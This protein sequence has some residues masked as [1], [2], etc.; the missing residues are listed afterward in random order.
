M[1]ACRKRS[2]HGPERIRP[3]YICAAGPPLS[4]SRD[5]GM[6]KLV[7]KK[8][9]RRGKNLIGDE[10]DWTEGKSKSGPIQDLGKQDRDLSCNNAEKLRV[11]GP[12]GRFG[13]RFW[14]GWGLFESRS[15]DIGQADNRE[16]QKEP[17]APGIHTKHTCL[18]F[19]T[20]YTHN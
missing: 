7:K 9:K 8:K 14:D 20:L 1:R 15:L 13:F 17:L 6:Y 19:D 12:L 2:P 16:T 4:C 11:H 10:K 18:P 3:M 5:L